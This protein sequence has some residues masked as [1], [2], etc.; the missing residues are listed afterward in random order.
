M[1]ESHCQFCSCIQWAKV[2]YWPVSSSARRQASDVEPLLLHGFGCHCRRRALY[3]CTADL[4]PEDGM[5]VLSDQGH[6]VVYDE[7][8]HEV[9]LSRA[10][11]CAMSPLV[12]FQGCFLRRLQVLVVSLLRVGRVVKSPNGVAG[13]LFELMYATFRILYFAFMV[14]A[15][16]RVSY[17]IKA[18]ICR[19]V[20]RQKWFSCSATSRDFRL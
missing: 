17:I 3:R 13:D 2:K 9:E 6:L 18:P 14:P 11:F 19:S 16:C 12:T 8:L 1:R 20:R 4:M 10:H 15:R 5:L 7:G